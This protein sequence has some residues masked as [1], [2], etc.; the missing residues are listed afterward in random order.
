VAGTLTSR[1]KTTY[2]VEFF[3]N[4]LPGSRGRVYLGLAKVKTNASGVATFTFNGPLPPSGYP[5]ITATATDPNN[6]T[7]ELSAA[8]S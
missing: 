3:A 6:N 7:S 4:T 8:L 1:A 5:Y 2:T